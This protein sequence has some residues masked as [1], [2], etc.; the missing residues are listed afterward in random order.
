MTTVVVGDDLPSMP[1]RTPLTPSLLTAIRLCAVAITVSGSSTTTRAG[2]SSLLNLGVTARLELIS[3]RTPSA[4]GTTFTRDSWLCEPV[5]GAETDA[6]FFS[7]ATETDFF[8]GTTETGFDPGITA[9]FTA[10]AGEPGTGFACAGTP[11]ASR[12]ALVSLACFCCSD[13]ATL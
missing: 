13:L 9:G 1:M 10:G 6:G 7:G 3:T 8:A 5:P 11:A 2:L 12:A 4:P